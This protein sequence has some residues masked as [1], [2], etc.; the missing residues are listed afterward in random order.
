MGLD[1][2]VCVPFIID[3]I[4]P[5]IVVNTALTAQF[6]EEFSNQH[7]LSYNI[8]GGSGDTLLRS[9]SWM[10]IFGDVNNISRGDNSVVLTSRHLKSGV[11]NVKMIFT[12]QMKT[13]TTIDVIV[14][15]YKKAEF[16]VATKQNNGGQDG[17]LMM[18]IGFG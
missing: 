4:H 13:E 6:V 15:V 18:N 1:T 8:Q 5:K 9:I 7:V 14:H 17:S 16:P 11:H 12:D 3:F 2:S 10:G